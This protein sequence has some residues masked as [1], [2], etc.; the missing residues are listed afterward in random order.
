MTTT[1]ITNYEVDHYKKE[2]VADTKYVYKREI[3]WRN[4]VMMT[5]LHG[6]AIYGYVSFA[7]DPEKPWWGAF[8]LDAIARLGA[9]GVTAGSHR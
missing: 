6:L 4:V 8:L 5:V 9:I 7:F 3:V 2:E 1:T